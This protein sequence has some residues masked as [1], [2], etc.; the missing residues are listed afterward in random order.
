MAA[1]DFIPGR[2]TE[3]LA[4]SRNFSAQ[5][6]SDP[7]SV[8]LSVAQAA[9]YAA[10]HLAYSTALATAT[11]PTTRT[12]GAVAAKKDARDFLESQARDL[13][14]IVNSFP[15]ITNQQRLDLGLRPRK[16][17][18]SPIHPPTDAPVMHVIATNGRTLQVRL[19]AVDSN[20]RAKPD[21][22][23]GA[24]IF[25]ALGPTPPADPAGWR[26]HGSTTRTRAYVA[27]DAS[28]PA[29]SQVW[30]M[31]SWFNP[32]SQAGP[33]STPITAYIAGGVAQAA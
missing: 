6:S 16:G 1:T 23:A 32:R 31:A 30:L 12:R 26:F 5:I 2:E 21:G 3:L 33:T 28:V 18:A 24:S 11:D 25:S 13:A 27:F 22:A 8:G 10:A 4:W 15:G 20:R 29:G 19:S 7:T 17:T 9:S 14:R